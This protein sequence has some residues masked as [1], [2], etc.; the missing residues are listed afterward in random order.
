MKKLSIVTAVHN[1]LEYSRLF[2][3][4]L[5]RHTVHPF[6]L[7]IIDNASHDGSAE[8]F[9]HAGATVLRNKKN[10]CYACAQNQGLQHAS[11]E[12][13]AFLNNDICLSN[14]WDKTL[15]EYLDEYKL[16]A[17]SPCGIETMESESA[18]RRAMRRWR[19]INA[20][21]RLRAAA[22]IRYTAHDLA[23][24]VRLM[25]GSWDR[26]TEKR[27][28]EFTRFLYPGISGNAV[29]A[30]RALF[31]KLGPWNTE[32]SA[33]D[34]DLQLRLVKAQSET[35]AARQ[36]MIAGDVFVHHFI[37]ATFRA[38]P[39]PHG[40]LHAC[41]D[42]TGHYAK[43]DLVYL[44][45]PAV[46]VIIAVHN[47][48]DFL[49]KVFAS[50]ANQTVRDFEVVV[51][52][53]GSGPEIAAL[54]K[55]WQGRFGHPVGHV[56]QEHR[57]FR[58]TIIAN[59]AVAASRSDYL[60]F[61]D[62]D[63]VLHHR[64]LE[65][66]LVNRRVHAVLSGRRVMLPRALTESLTLADI[67]GRRVEK[68][69]FLRRR[70]EDGS[71]K[72]A[73]RLPGLPRAENLFGKEY[74]ILGSNF[75]VYKGDYYAVNGYDETLTGRGLEDNNLCARF[76]RRGLH[77]RTITREAI[78]YHLFHSSEPIPHDRAAIQKYGHPD[79]YWA[80]KGIVQ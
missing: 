43:K 37:R 33:P 1:Q 64:F 65:S 29:V 70:V 80:E 74:W 53:D 36:C 58:K 51:A 78:Q 34:W 23:R 15:I 39:A 79:H 10:L 27:R 52:D 76:K 5:K 7:I 17:I 21:Q 46:S 59:R 49:E 26:F 19:R 6:E 35:G 41:T 11:A 55:Q 50:L 12:F 63:S 77:V 48:P 28:R 68:L 73:V 16:D 20:L 60:C 22:G 40:C 42:I 57:G 72:Y 31:E 69:S 47:R 56:R 4:S 38:S 62:G 44:R 3:E 54:V 45:R 13:V 61:I 30:R 71:I 14:A 66:H 2:F 25:Y 75:S 67:T 32:V 18:T 9:E 8:F 24:L